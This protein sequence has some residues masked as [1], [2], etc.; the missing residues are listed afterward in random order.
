VVDS[1]G[2][3]NDAHE[4]CWRVAMLEPFSDHTQR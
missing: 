3:E 1:R 2:F 4:F